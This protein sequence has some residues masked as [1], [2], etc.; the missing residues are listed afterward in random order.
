M[1]LLFLSEFNETWIFSADFR[2]IL[3]YNFHENPF[4]ESRVFPTRMDRHMRKFSRFFAILRTHLEILRSA[5]TAYLC[6]LCGSQNIQ[7]LFPYTASSDW[8]V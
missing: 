4:S 6:V 2:K 1:C 8:F 7:R 3:K 5:H